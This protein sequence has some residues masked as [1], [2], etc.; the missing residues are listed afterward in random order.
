MLILTRDVYLPPSISVIF[1]NHAREFLYNSAA[2]LY[3]FP[4]SIFAFRL[5]FR[6]TGL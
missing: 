5:I 4:I 2:T 1:R 3:S 6:K